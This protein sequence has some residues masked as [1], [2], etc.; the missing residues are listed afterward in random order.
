MLW[1]KLPVLRRGLSGVAMVIMAGVCRAGE[2]GPSTRTVLIY[3]GHMA[4]P[5]NGPDTRGA[6]SF[7][8]RL[9]YEFNDAISAMLAQPSNQ[10]PG[11]AYELVPATRNRSL[12][13]RVEDANT[14]RP[15]LYIEIHHDS[16]QPDDLARARDEGPG[17]E[18]WNA[19]RGFSVHYSEQSALPGASKT[20]AEFLGTEMIARGAVPNL[21]H[22]DREGMRCVDR[23]RG[24][25][26][27][28][29]PHG[30]F[31]LYQIKSPCVVFECGTIANPAEEKELSTVERQRLIVAAINQAIQK[32]FKST[33]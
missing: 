32:F 11:V 24:I 28:V 27:R 3:S 33:E 23:K 6:A 21:Y 12:K 9:E 15:G 13:A 8:G 2:P 31:V 16:A 26:D 29:P 25:Y 7:R 19:I 22:A 4:N 1:R 30:L 20:F 14:R 17:S 10:I 5:T 18:R